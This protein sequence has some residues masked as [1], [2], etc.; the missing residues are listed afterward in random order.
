VLDSSPTPV[1]AHPYGRLEYAASL[2]HLGEACEIPELN[3]S[4]VL[5]NIRDGLVARV[6]QSDGILR[7]GFSCDSL[8]P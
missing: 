4:V 6:I 1:R 7:V 8:S 2:H 3:S 5:R